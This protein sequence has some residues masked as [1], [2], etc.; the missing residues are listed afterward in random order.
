MGDIEDIE[1]G[2]LFT[3]YDII[4]DGNNEIEMEVRAIAAEAVGIQI[5]TSIKKKTM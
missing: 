1:E 2:G 3:F 4:K 5:P